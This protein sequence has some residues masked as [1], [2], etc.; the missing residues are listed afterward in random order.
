MNPGNNET[1]NDDLDLDCAFSHDYLKTDPAFNPAEV[2]GQK[3]Y[4]IATTTAAGTSSRP[5]EAAKGLVNSVLHPGRTFVQHFESKTSKSLSKATRPYITPQADREFLAAHDALFEAEREGGNE[6]AHKSRGRGRVF[7]GESRQEKKDRKDR[8]NST[9][10]NV[11]DQDRQPSTN[12]DTQRK[13]VELLEAHRQSV[14]VAWI[15]SRHLKCVRLAPSKVAVFPSFGDEKFIERDENGVEVRFMWERY[16]GQVR[17]PRPFPSSSF[18]LELD[19]FLPRYS[20]FSTIP[21]PSRRDMWTS[22]YLSLR[23][24]LFRW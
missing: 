14:V 2:S 19:Q 8:D 1:N 13:K 21:N 16:I 12:A 15:T 10:G 18:A 17:L 7:S 9:T 23:L 3:P 11:S 24:T 20:F 22:G 6:P 4:S 5:L